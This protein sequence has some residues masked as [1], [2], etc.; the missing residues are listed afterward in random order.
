MLGAPSAGSGVSG[1]VVERFQQARVGEILRSA[2]G[3]LHLQQ[4]LTMGDGDR[5][6]AEGNLVSASAQVGERAEVSGKREDVQW[7]V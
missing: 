2:G 1:C 4:I 3:A 6:V 5:E 7:T